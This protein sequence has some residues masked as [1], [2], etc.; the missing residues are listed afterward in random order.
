MA[1]KDSRKRDLFDELEEAL[2]V[3]IHAPQPRPEELVDEALRGLGELRRA[4]E[5]RYELP[6]GSVVAVA[7]RPDKRRQGC[8]VFTV[9]EVIWT[10]KHG[11]DVPG[12]VRRA[13]T[14]VVA[15]PDKR[16][17]PDGCVT[18]K[19]ADEAARLYLGEAGASSVK[20]LTVEVVRDAGRYVIVRPHRHVFEARWDMGVVFECR[21]GE[22][23]RRVREPDKPFR[24]DVEEWIRE[25][26]DEARRLNVQLPREVTRRMGLWQRLAEAF[27]EAVACVRNRN[28]V[29]RL[30]CIYRVAKEFV[31][32]VGAEDAY[33]I[34]S[35]LFTFLVDQNVE[36]E[37][38]S[39]LSLDVR[40]LYAERTGKPLER[41]LYSACEIAR[42]AVM[43]SPPSTPRELRVVYFD[44]GID[45]CEHKVALSDGSCLSTPHCYDQGWYAE[46][47][48]FVTEE[49]LEKLDAWLRDEKK[50][51][52]KPTA[53][54]VEAFVKALLSGDRSVAEEAE[55]RE[56]LREAYRRFRDALTD[57]VGRRDEVV[58]VYE[59]PRHWYIVRR[60]VREPQRR[61]RHLACGKR[62]VCYGGYEEVPGEAEVERIDK[63]TLKREVVTLP[64]VE[65]R[66]REEEGF[67]VE[68]YREKRIAWPEKV[69]WKMLRKWL[70]DEDVENMLRILD[71]AAKAADL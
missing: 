27:E 50:R 66:W 9:T 59:S 69:E 45:E 1:L 52:R 7:L 8:F 14:G 41:H 39:L 60:I 16:W 44:A 23:A 13:R 61:C 53:E 71:E 36:A 22:R 65:A 48:T 33:S 58:E 12:D 67:G 51:G 25:V 30:R 42:W 3:Q 5:A 55:R 47:G 20:Y 38:W 62:C 68:P 19:V 21:C 6:P 63:Q 43:K 54:E 37:A 31:D 24:L 2:G 35:K 18:Q 49:V 40:G 28:G 64:V 4:V 29:E 11:R 34:V 15:L 32:R 56:R 17:V 70:G 26:L 46:P 57:L 10:P